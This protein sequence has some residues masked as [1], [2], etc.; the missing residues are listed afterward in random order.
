MTFSR[1]IT[2][3]LVLVTTVAE[4]E[5]VVTWTLDG[6]GVQGVTVQN[7]DV[8]TD[9]P[10][11]LHWTK[12]T[13]RVDLPGE[14]ISRLGAGDFTISIWAMLD[15]ADPAGGDILFAEDGRGNGL[16]LA[17]V[18]RTGSTSSLSADRQL[19]VSLCDD[20]NDVRWMDRGRPGRA[21][22]VHSLAVHGG[23]LYAGVC[24]PGESDRGEVYVY[25]GPS[26]WVSAGS[27]DD[28]NDVTALASYRG[29]LFAGTGK[30]R[31]A[32]SSL[33]ES[34]NS[35]R[36]GRV[37]RQESD[38]TWRVVGELPDADAVGGMTVFKNRLW[39]SSL[40]KP[41]RLYSL[42]VNEV[43][44]EEAL[45][46]PERRVESMGVHAGRLYATSYDNAHV[47]RHDGDSWVD[48]G[49]VGEN[50]QTYG[51]ASYRGRLYVSTWPSGRVYRLDD[52]EGWEDTGRL[53]EE[54]EVMG[55]AVHRGKLWGGTLPLA[56]VYCYREG[57][58][59]KKSGNVDATSSVKYRRAWTMAVHQGELFVGTLPSGHVWSTSVGQAVSWD[60]AFPDGWH[61]V[62][63]RRAGAEL[64]VWVDGRQVGRSTSDGDRR[65]SLDQVRKL[66]LGRGDHYAFRGR[67][68][69]LRVHS[70]SLT[71]EAIKRE[72]LLRPQ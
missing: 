17:I 39:V 27:P 54:L 49:L 31:L 59:W 23:R 69:D 35:H 20:E 1:I 71:D 42:D 64:T 68:R 44:K 2:I 43:W 28:S 8:T 34:T 65:V 63:M 47:Y 70:S 25:Q 66:T 29:F 6:S 52:S 24:Q 37:Y 16:S 19:I 62:A 15:A 14:V 13:S 12:E 40:Y 48:L 33:A 57:G 60:R 5:D 41:A 4:A 36:G 51:F 56:D 58:P 50:T 38:G 61:H 11:G 30:Y 7:V 21:T 55:L 32:G 46:E 72:S 26:E 45:P 67:L 53:G 3:L 9:Q 18:T 10:R 22:Y